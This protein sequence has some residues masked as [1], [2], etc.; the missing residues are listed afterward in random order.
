ME[1]KGF[2]LSRKLNISSV[3]ILTMRVLRKEMDMAIPELSIDRL[4]PTAMAPL[5]MI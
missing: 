4:P 2:R 3:N 5:R 1:G